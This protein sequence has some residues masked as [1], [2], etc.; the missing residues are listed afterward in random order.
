MRRISKTKDTKIYTIELTEEEVNTIDASLDYG[1]S[2]L[3]HN[4]ST[5]K[6]LIQKMGDLLYKFDFIDED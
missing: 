1:R 3:R 6:E 2:Y 5:E 4:K